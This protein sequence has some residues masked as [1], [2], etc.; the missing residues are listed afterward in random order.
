[1]TAGLIVFPFWPSLIWG[2][3]AAGGQGAPDGTEKSSARQKRKSFSCLGE[4][5]CSSLTPM[6]GSLSWGDRLG[7]FL[8]PAHLQIRLSND[9]GSS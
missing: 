9:A 7:S 6:R 8:L 3:W 5:V 1:M 4:C 2:P